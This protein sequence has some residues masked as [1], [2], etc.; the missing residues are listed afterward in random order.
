MI[1]GINDSPSNLIAV[2]KYALQNHALQIHL[3]P[4][5]K[6]GEAKW[7]GLDYSYQLKGKSEPDSQLIERAYDILSSCGIHVNIGGYSG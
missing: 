2:A 4:F 5:H 3:L 1:P 6:I 7:E